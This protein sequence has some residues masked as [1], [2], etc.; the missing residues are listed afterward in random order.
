MGC[1]DLLEDIPW[2]SENIRRGS[3]NPTS[4]ESKGF[5]SK[6]KSFHGRSSSKTYNVKDDEKISSEWSCF[7]LVVCTS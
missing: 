4:P 1:Q 7:L 5:M 6:S 2:R 3:I